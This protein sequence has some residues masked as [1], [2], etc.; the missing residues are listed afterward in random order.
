MPKINKKI[1]LLLASGTTLNANAN[2]STFFV[3]SEDDI[4]KWLSAMPELSLLANIQAEFIHGE[5]KAL[6]I[7]SI[8]TIVQHLARM[9]DEADGFIVLVRANRLIYTAVSAEFM[10]QGFGKPIIFT[11][12]RY[13]PQDIAANEIKKLI[14]MG[15]L[16]LRSNLINA[17]QVSLANDFP[18]MGIMYGNKLIKPTH[19]EISDFQAMNLF[20][21]VDNSYLG[22]IDFGISLN[23][24]VAIAGKPMFYSYLSRDVAVTNSESL[25]LLLASEI[26]STLFKVL[27]VRMKE[28]EIL[29]P[30][31]II[32]LRKRFKIIV[33]FNERRLVDQRGVISI[34]NMTWD[35]AQIKAFWAD[36]VAK[37]PEE[38]EELMKRNVVN[39]F[40]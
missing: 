39:E 25:P 14:K 1:S 8:E 5:D 34:S 11:G 23:R 10:L 22:K 27:L 4:S 38:F 29:A 3:N 6:G 20:K 28:N 35:T 31:M 18:V 30:D 40:I 21:S 37:S 17:I 33:L 12:S 2:K 24:K 9:R 16:G 32:E 36:G 13:A 7:D 19:A 26:K 15:H